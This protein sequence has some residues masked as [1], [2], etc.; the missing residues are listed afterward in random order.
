M[1]QV[2]S[3]VVWWA[4]GTCAYPLGGDRNTKQHS[5]ARKHK[6]ESNYVCTGNHKQTKQW[7]CVQMHWEAMDTNVNYDLYLS[8]V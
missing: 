3:T 8:S 4:C 5:L 7:P 1:M 6:E 2:V